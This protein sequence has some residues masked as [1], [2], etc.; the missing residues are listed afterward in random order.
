MLLN[1]GVL[2]GVRVLS[3]QRVSE[4]TSPQVAAPL[5]PNPPTTLVGG[6]YGFGLAG[7]V[8]VDATRTD[9]PGTTGIYRWNGYVGTYFWIDPRRQ[10]VAMVW[11]QHNPG[12][13]Y[14]LE[15]VFQRMVYDA[16][17]N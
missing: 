16:L 9:L 1:G 13:Q 10:L 17:V 12:R 5:L 6:G 2:N 8:L 11:T 15:A 4:M 7:S 3:P 14:P